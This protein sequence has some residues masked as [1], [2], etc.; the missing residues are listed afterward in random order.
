MKN[1]SKNSI[2]KRRPC[3]IATKLPLMNLCSGCTTRPLSRERNVLHCKKESS[4]VLVKK[5][6]KEKKRELKNFPWTIK[7]LPFVWNEFIPRVSMPIFFCLILE[8]RIYVKRCHARGVNC[9][10][11]DT[12]F[13]YTNKD[14]CEFWKSEN[15]LKI[16]LLD[17]CRIE[18]I[19]CL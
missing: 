1:S 3:L 11:D 18:I 7:T 17:A 5:K 12:C 2:Y 4:K 15:W 19:Y 10:N 13:V 16:L 14:T 8:F 9:A 6:K